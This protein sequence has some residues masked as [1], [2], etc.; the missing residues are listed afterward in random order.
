MDL[1]TIKDVAVITGAIGTPVVVAI[2]GVIV[3]R[4]VARAGLQKD[5]VQLALEILREE[6]PKTSKEMRQ[7]AVD[8]LERFSPVAI[9][10]PLKV[11]LAAG[12]AL[13][14]PNAPTDFRVS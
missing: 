3:Q 4:S 14:R 2:I 9:S 6:P 13:R 12:G 5:Y 10:A 7:W 11:S 1:N 8:V